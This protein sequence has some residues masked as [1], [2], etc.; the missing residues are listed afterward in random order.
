MYLSTFHRNWFILRMQSRVNFMDYLPIL[1]NHPCST[2]STYSNKT[3][4][5]YIIKSIKV[6]KDPLSNYWYHSDPSAWIYSS[7][8]Y[9][10]PEIMWKTNSLLRQKQFTFFRPFQT[11]FHFLRYKYLSGESHILIYETK[12]R[13]LWLAEFLET[14]F[15]LQKS[16]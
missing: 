7:D 1:T 2:F 12:I 9:Y 15:K 5:L 10:S 13:K 11:T 16:L 8:V 14:C 6:F 4:I 3:G